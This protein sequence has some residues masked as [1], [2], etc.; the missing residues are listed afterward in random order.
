MTFEIEKGFGE[1]SGLFKS[2]FIGEKIGECVQG[3]L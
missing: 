2:D 1:D 3:D